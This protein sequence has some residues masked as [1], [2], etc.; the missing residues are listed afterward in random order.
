VWLAYRNLPAPLA[1]WYVANWFVVSAIRQPHRAGDLAR[2][3]ADGWRTRPRAS[4]AA[5]RWHTVARLTML[6][7][8]PIL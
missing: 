3:I 8:P 4:R 5:I 7:R 1:L 2:G 6:G